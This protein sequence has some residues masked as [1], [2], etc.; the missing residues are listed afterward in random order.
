MKTYVVNIRDKLIEAEGEQEALA[1]ALESIANG[2]FN[3][4][5]T[6]QNGS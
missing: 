5:A 4:V 3:L 2:D 6:Q 1:S